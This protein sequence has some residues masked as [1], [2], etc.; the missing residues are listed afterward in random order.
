MTKYTRIGGVLLLAAL[1]AAGGWLYFVL[2]H[3][4]NSSTLTLYGNVDIR[5]VQLAF[6]DNGRVVSMLAREGAIVRKG[7]LLATMDD[8]SYVAELAQA[9]AQA[10]SA[11][12]T[13]ARLKAGSRPEEIA[14]AKATMEALAAT[15]V[16]AKINYER[17]VILA[18]TRAISKQQRD[19]AKATHDSTAQQYDAARQAYILAVKG[20]RD[21]D[22]RAAENNFQAAQAAVASA[23]KRLTDTKLYAPTDGIIEN[24]ILE[25]GDMAAPNTPVYTIALQQPLWVR[26]YSAETDLGKI[27]QGMRAAVTTDSFPGHVYHGWVGYISPTAEFTPKNVETT[28]LRTALVYQLRVYVCNSLNQLRLGMPATAEID[29]SPV[30]PNA[31]EPART[32]CG[33]S[34][35]TDR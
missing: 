8:V 23:Q 31:P 24:R 19:E 22:I 1:A 16:N 26:A 34:D 9:R 5:E 6:N 27:A 35:A 7:E 29:L 3:R 30:S 20:P 32:E 17:M 11:G 13:L 10:A 4:T 15:L 2:S 12:Q 14:Q 21:E 25:P 33:A 28:T 18:P